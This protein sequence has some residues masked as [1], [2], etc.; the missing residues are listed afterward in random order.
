MTYHEPAPAQA[1]VRMKAPALTGPMGSGSTRA[2]DPVDTSGTIMQ[3]K[4]G[5]FFNSD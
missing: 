4:A 1:W 3:V 5:R 2:D